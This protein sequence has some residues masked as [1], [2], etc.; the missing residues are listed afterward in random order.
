MG[1]GGVDAQ[2]PVPP[3]EIFYS[4][5]SAN[6]PTAKML[7]RGQGILEI[8]HRFLPPISDGADVLWGLDGPAYNRLGFGFA[9]D[10]DILLGV[11]R[12]SL[13]DN[14]EINAKV[15]LGQK[16]GGRPWMA[17]AVLG[18]SWDFD[19]HS[20]GSDAV[21]HAY[22]QIVFNTL[23]TDRIAIGVVPSLFGG[24]S[25]EGSAEMDIAFGFSGQFYLNRR[26]NLIA[27][28]IATQS[29]TVAPRDVGSLGIE[30]RT[31]GHFF[32]ILLSNQVRMNPSQYLMGSPFSL[33]PKEWRLG[34]NVVRILDF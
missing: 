26:I 23:L 29:R 17:A 9:V 27:E 12:S 7:E 13:E 5:Q 19:S 6:L 15:N 1:N 22:L 32:K 2:E 8:S 30:F 28:W 25:E 3:P 14:L 34:F 4:T 31:R 18:S 20:R 10:D 24:F 16:D 33:H 21:G 11:L